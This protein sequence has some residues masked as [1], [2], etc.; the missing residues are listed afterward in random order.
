MY[1]SCMVESTDVVDGIITRTTT[2]LCVI[3]SPLRIGCL[4]TCANHLKSKHAF[5]MYPSSN[6]ICV[7]VIMVMN[8]QIVLN[9]DKLV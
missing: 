6:N 5:F 1:L 2:L 7:V 3:R 9:V 8:S 4:F